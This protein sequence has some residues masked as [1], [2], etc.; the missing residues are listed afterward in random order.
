MDN[1]IELAMQIIFCLLI[2]AI[3]GAIIGYLLGKMSKCDKNDYDLE[4]RDRDNEKKILNDYANEEEEVKDLL[5]SGIDKTKGLAAA[6]VAGVGA[7]GAGVYEG[8]KNLS[9]NIV[10]D[11]SKITREIKEDHTNH[12]SVG[13]E[14]GI[15]PPSV[16]APKNGETDDLKEISGIGLKIEEILNSLGIYYFEQIS[17]WSPENIEWIEN[18]LSVKRR[19]KKEDWIGQA[20]L[21]AAGG[22]TEF[23]KGVKNGNNRN[24]Q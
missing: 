22:Q 6:G 5:S 7:V 10:D 8:T 17:E 9:S 16:E 21:L 24:Y 2:A 11:S 18:Y 23:S 14:I 20:A 4:P 13:Q 12:I 19:V 3:I 1:L 15:R